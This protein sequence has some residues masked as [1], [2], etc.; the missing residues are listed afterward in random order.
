MALRRFW[1]KL[2]LR[3]GTQAVRVRVL[4]QMGVCIGERCRIYTDRFGGEPYLIRIGDHVCISND[5]TFV[6]HGLTWPFQDKHDSLTSFGAIDIRDNVQIGVGATIL[7]GVTIGPHAIVGACSVVTKDVAPG[8]VVAGNPARVITTMDEFEQK[9][10]AS[11]IAIP[12]DR[13]GMRRVLEAHFWG[14]GEKKR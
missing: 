11:H 7:P 2:L 10:V 14:N 8:T 4:R 1:H 3:Y 13:A 5:V 9:C 6:N 12:K